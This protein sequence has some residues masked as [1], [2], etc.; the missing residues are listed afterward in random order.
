MEYT[1][2]EIAG[3]ERRLRKLL[4]RVDSGDIQLF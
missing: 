2:K 1:T 3:I 4:E